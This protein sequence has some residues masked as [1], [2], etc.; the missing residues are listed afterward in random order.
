MSTETLPPP[1]QDPAIEQPVAPLPEHPVAIESDYL[2]PR[3]D[4]L[5]DVA[6]PLAEEYYT[7]PET[8]YA[9]NPLE[10]PPQTPTA[11]SQRWGRLQG[12]WQRVKAGTYGATAGRLRAL[13]R[14]EAYDA[15]KH[16]RVVQNEMYKSIG[17][18]AVREHLF[19][20]D[21][22]RFNRYASHQLTRGESLR[23][24]LEEIGSLVPIVG[25]L[26]LRGAGKLLLR[27]SKLE[28][29]GSYVG[30]A[31]A[32]S[33]DK[34]LSSLKKSSK[35]AAAA[36]ERKRAVSQTIVGAQQNARVKSIWM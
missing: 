13:K 16:N 30:L 35:N 15:T 1:V 36:H 2:G 4:I 3:N 28:S 27:N 24:N 7:A 33:A 21:P 32:E 34:A 9:D 6:K 26:A 22:K 17:D 31:A 23:Q 5:N 20:Y 12:T 10:S 25:V 29:V 19:A 18:L 11:F 8:F 14:G